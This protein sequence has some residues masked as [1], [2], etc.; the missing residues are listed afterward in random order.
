MHNAMDEIEIAVHELKNARE[1]LNVKHLGNLTHVEKEMEDMCNF[2]S[3]SGRINM[4]KLNSAR[5]SK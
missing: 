1:K 2:V 5:E 4:S 3:E